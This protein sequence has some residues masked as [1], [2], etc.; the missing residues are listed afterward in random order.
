MIAGLFAILSLSFNGLALADWQDWW[1]TPEQQAAE[2]FEEGDHERLLEQAPDA[3]WTGL[4]HYQNGDYDAAAQAFSER[5]SQLQQQGDAKAA[6]QALFNKGVSDVRAGRYEE[7][8]D[9]FDAILESDP[10]FADAAFNRDIAERLK[11]LQQQQEQP[12]QGEEGEQG[13]QGEQGDSGDD[14]S[15]GE[16]G[17][18]GDSD[19]AGQEPGEEASGD[20][21]S[22]EQPAEESPGQQ[23]GESSETGQES[24]EEQG[25][26]DGA[27]ETEAERQAAAE[28]AQRA[29]DAEARQAQE[30]EAADAGSVSEDTDERALSESEQATEQLLRRIPDDPAGL[31]RRRLEQSH[32]NKYPEV[33][34]GR[35]A[36]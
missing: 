17:Q 1:Q 11:T 26:E 5:A 27:A 20:S 12:Q 31:L 16:Q 29:L 19:N 33:R 30:N 14:S 21:E 9:E 28:A 7:A 25:S 24:S 15:S 23:S 18:D 22:G 10:D 8:V 4:G 35:E 2:A 32:R 13:E 34:D 3:G 36:W 6:N